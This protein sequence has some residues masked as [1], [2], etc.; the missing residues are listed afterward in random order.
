MLQE[1]GQRTLSSKLVKRDFKDQECVQKTQICQLQ[2]WN[3]EA[4]LINSYS[5]R[6]PRF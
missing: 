3:P 4:I 6:I 5:S 1:T 2:Y